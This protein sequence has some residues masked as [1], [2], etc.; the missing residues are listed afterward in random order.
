MLFFFF[1]TFKLPLYLPEKARAKKHTEEENVA[2]GLN[3]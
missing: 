2:M 3:C 1:L